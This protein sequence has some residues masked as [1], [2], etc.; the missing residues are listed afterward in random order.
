MS[1]RLHA[2]DHVWLYYWVKMGETESAWWYNR[3]EAK[4]ALYR[5]LSEGPG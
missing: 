3:F 2:F 5:T 4:C 1:A